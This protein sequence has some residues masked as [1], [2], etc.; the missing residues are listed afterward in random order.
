LLSKKLGVGKSWS[1]DQC[2][3]WHA[4]LENPK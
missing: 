3:H 4:M 1:P 2:I